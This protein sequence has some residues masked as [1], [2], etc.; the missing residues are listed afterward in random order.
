VSDAS[1]D[2]A[3]LTHASVVR[4]AIVPRATL[5]GAGRAAIFGV[6]PGV[7]MDT[8]ALWALQVSKAEFER[9]RV[10]EAGLAATAHVLAVRMA[11]VGRANT[12]GGARVLA[13][14]RAA[15]VSVLVGSVADAGALSRRDLTVRGFLE[16]RSCDAADGGGNL[17]LASL[18]VSA[19]AAAPV[20]VPP[21]VTAAVVLVAGV[22][23]RKA[24]SAGREGVVRRRRSRLTVTGLPT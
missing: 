9:R 15:V 22:V 23:A 17:V 4:A 20:E 6:I 2:V 21:V 7:L 1:T 13:G 12:A 5:S 11:R 8:G 10:R 3:G 19:L 24:V 18:A 14:G 16:N